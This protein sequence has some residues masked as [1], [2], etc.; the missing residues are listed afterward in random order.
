LKS[1]GTLLGR[2]KDN[3]RC[4][5][6]YGDFIAR[7]TDNTAS[8]LADFA[9][10]TVF[11]KVKTGKYKPAQLCNRKE[12]DESFLDAVSADVDK[13][14]LLKY[15][16]VSPY[17]AYLFID[18]TITISLKNGLNYIP[19]LWTR[20]HSGLDDQLSYDRILQD[21]RVVYND[22]EIHPAIVNDN[23]YA[24]LRD[25]KI[26]DFKGEA[27]D[28]L[29]KQYDK[30]PRE[31][32]RQIL[33]AC[34]TALN[35]KEQLHRFYQQIFEPLHNKLKTYLVAEDN[36][37]TFSLKN[38]FFIVTNE[39]DF[40]IAQQMNLPV[41]CYYK[42]KVEPEKY[43]FKGKLLDLEASKFIITDETD[44]SE[45]FRYELSQRMFYLLV[46]LSDA[47][48]SETNYFENP[49]KITELSRKLAGFKFSEVLTL[50]REVKVSLLNKSII[51]DRT[52]DYTEKQL[53]ARKDITVAK[54][55]EAIA[56]SVF[57][58][59]KF[60]R[61]VEL[62]LFHKNDETLIKEYKDQIATFHQEYKS[63]WIN[64][65]D[66]RFKKF[67]ECILSLYDGYDFFNDRQWFVCN[68]DYESPFLIGLYRSG[69]LNQLVQSINAESEI[70]E[71]GVFSGFQLDIDF[72]MYKNYLA[73]IEVVL[74]HTGVNPDDILR[75]RLKDLVGKLGIASEIKSL[76]DN[77]VTI[78]PNAFD[79][80]HDS[81]NLEKAKKNVGL[82]SKIKQIIHNFKDVPIKE[83]NG[84]SVDD[85]AVI[86]PIFV[87]TREVIYQGKVQS[88]E[89]CKVVG[90]T[91]EEQVLYFFINNFITTVPI[92]ER[93]KALSAVDQ[94][95]KSK[96]S[97]SPET[98]FLHKSIYDACIEVM[99]DDQQLRA[100]LVPFF[101]ITLHYQ[102]AFVDLI[103][104]YDGKAMLVEV[105]T[106][107][108]SGN[109]GFRI[110]ESEINQAM[111]Q[112]NYMIIRVTPD[113]MVLLGNPIFKI[114]E[115]I[116][117]IEGSNFSIQPDGYKFKFFK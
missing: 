43:G 71:D 70:F 9:L 108:L 87:R 75:V 98:L 21:V 49:S 78:Y 65:Y 79:I 86:A 67:T 76:R 73:E 29:I 110:S 68:S 52:F 103:T 64:D 50:K 83:I 114:Q 41:L 23:K 17:N 48:Y 4:T 20:D 27:E 90:D 45:Q 112:E 57:N 38:D 59:A 102:L 44:C 99:L 24:F 55:A 12:I 111:S 40:Q 53:Y 91:G 37:L 66:K 1:I 2:T 93:L 25:L 72:S 42:S 8:N 116:T 32:M 80:T 97:K 82:Q 33:A 3:I 101:Y 47:S 77:I 18:N 96:L 106:T 92:E 14:V 95:I 115:K 6:R 13:E 26:N 61:T 58:N 7:K 54:R 10:A 60:S 89:V 11:L 104:W 35:R 62:I 117:K 69:R 16:G 15:L 56:K 85:Q 36:G 74:N 63:H 84:F 94:L 31:Y 22:E 100:A 51:S 5:H 109:N 30:F 28:L 19:A 88:A 107:N 34:G 46:E 113:E 39:S 81:E 105:K